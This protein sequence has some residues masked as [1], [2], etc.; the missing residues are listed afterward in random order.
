[1]NDLGKVSVIDEL[2]MSITDRVLKSYNL[3]K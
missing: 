2:I 3:Q 1:M